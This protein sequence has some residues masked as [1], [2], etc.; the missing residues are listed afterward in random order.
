MR[1]IKLRKLLKKLHL[2]LWK[3]IHLI[4]NTP[5]HLQTWVKYIYKIY[6]R[7]T[8]VPFQA[9]SGQVWICFC[10]WKRII[11]ICGFSAK[12][13]YAFL[14]SEKTEKCTFILNNQRNKLLK[15]LYWI[16]EWLLFPVFGCNDCRNRREHQYCST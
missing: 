9:L 1:I 3:T 7:I 8:T 15:K 16:I 13:I 12:V 6:V 4:Q 2:I 14:A 5:C 11:F 10:F